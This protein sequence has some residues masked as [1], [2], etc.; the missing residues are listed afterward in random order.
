MKRAHVI[1]HIHHCGTECI[2]RDGAPFCPV[3]MCYAFG[4]QD[5]ID[6]DLTP[7][8]PPEAA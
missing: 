8:E 3:C 5:V 1:K 7:D 2:R 6:V 4:V